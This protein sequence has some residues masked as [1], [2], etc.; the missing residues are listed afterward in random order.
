MA[1][2]GVSVM[3]AAPADDCRAYR[4]ASIPSGER[5]MW[6]TPLDGGGVG[7]GLGETFWGQTIVNNCK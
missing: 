1:H 6:T 7:A 3:V 4:A 5:D 2:E